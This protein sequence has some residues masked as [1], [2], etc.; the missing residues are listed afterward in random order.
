MLGIPFYPC[1]LLADA[2]VSPLTGKPAG[3]SIFQLAAFF[4]AS[5]MLLLTRTENYYEATLTGSER[6]GRLKEAARQGSFSA[7]FAARTRN[8]AKVMKDRSRPYTLPLFGRGASAVFW[9]HLSSAAKRPFVNFVLPFSGGLASAIV[10]LMWLPGSAVQI[11]AGI[12]AYVTWSFL[13]IATRSS[14][15]QCVQLRSLVR[16][17]PIRPWKVVVADVTPIGITGSLFGWGASLALLGYGGRD[18][19]IAGVALVFAAP[20]LVCTLA[21][22]QYVVTLWYPSAQDKMQ[23]LLSGFV[24]LALFGATAIVLAPFVAVPLVLNASLPAALASGF[25]GCLAVVFG[26]LLLASSVFRRVEVP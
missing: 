21:L 23:Q 9:A 20:A 4:A 22:I 8:R 7:V 16:P 3:G 10:C 11:V 13:L 15:R 18:R 24:S 17:F 25:I 12:D 26:F 2:F 1:R 14:F 5:L 6:V 19:V